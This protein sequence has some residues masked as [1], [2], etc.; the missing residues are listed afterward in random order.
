[1]L[2]LTAKNLPKI[3][4]KRGKSG[5]MGK[6]GK[7]GRKGNNREGSFTLPLLTDRAGYATSCMIIIFQND[8]KGWGKDYLNPLPGEF[9]RFSTA[10]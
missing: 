1:M 3:G 5:K 4:K 10:S 2:P 9:S 7:S 8:N 6:G